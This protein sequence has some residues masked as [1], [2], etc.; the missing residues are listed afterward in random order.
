MNRY[1][2]GGLTPGIPRPLARHPHALA[3]GLASLGRG[4]DSTLVHMSPAEVQGLQKLAM[5]HGG[6]LTINPHT[7]LP[8]AD[9][10]SKLLPLL[11]GVLTGAFAPE[12]LPYEATATGLVAKGAGAN[13]GQAIMAGLSAYG[14]GSAVGSINAMNAGS[15]LVAETP[16]I[17]ANVETLAPVEVPAMTIP[18]SFAGDIP[19]AGTF[20]T[21][22]MTSVGGA[23][24]VLS[25]SVVPPPDTGAPVFN[26]TQNPDF[27]N[28]SAPA[29]S[30]PVAAG[31]GQIQTVYPQEGIPAH[32]VP[33]AGQQFMQH[34]V[35]ATKDFYQGLG[36]TPLS[37]AAAAGGIAAP[38]VQSLSTNPTSAVYDQKPTFY[39]QRPGGP[40]LYDRGT[41]NPNIA[42]LGYL[43]AGQSAFS[44][45]QFNSGVYSQSPTQYIP[46]VATAGSPVLTARDGGL[47]SLKRKYMASGGTS[48]VTPDQGKAI[49]ANSAPLPTTS[50]GSNQSTLDAMNQYYQGQLAQASAL[51]SQEI[52]PPPSS[53]AM[54]DYLAQIRQMNTPSTVTGGNV[55]PFPTLNSSYTAVSSSPGRRNGSPAYFMG[56]DLSKYT[57][58]NFGGP[59]TAGSAMTWDPATGSFVSTG[60]M[61]SYYPSY[62]NSILGYAYGG[63]INSMAGGGIASLQPTSYYAAGGKLLDGPGDGM[64]DSIPAV[65]TGNKPQQAALADGEFVVPADVVSHLGNG[66]TKAGSQKLYA[67]MDKVRMARTGKKKQAPQ[68][69]VDRFMPA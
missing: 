2:F 30:A 54:D 5:A 3:H 47:L 26:P 49:L 66:S 59:G 35:D 17:A 7:G 23:P 63:D 55:Q 52:P 16:G 9:F 67:M 38:V 6:S 68:V 33:N 36:S 39:I 13:W 64:S 27:L 48:S 24:G 44:G 25:S 29:V 18:D 4:G 62:G 51:P 53:A 19:S 20:T 42:K 41:V 37:R 28:P 61:G 45:Q 15:G 46:V 32:V 10:L 8:E 50:T 40:P 56:I 60:G 65:I 11:G 58:T 14:G 12:L 57:G 22:A 43:P 69:K 31:P 34:P 21:D 1:A